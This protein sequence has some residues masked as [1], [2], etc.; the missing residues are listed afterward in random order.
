MR[1]IHVIS[2]PAAGGAENYVRDLAINMATCGHRIHV[3]FLQPASPSESSKKYEEKFLSDLTKNGVSY[4]FIGK[5]A[6]IFPWR[7]AIALFR[8]ARGFRA[9]IVH[10]H[11]YYALIFSMLLPFSTVVYTHHSVRV[12]VPRMA[13]RI[14]DMKVSAYV[15]I[16]GPCFRLLKDC[17][18]KPVFQIDN[19]VDPRRLLSREPSCSEIK[20]LNQ[21][22]R[23]VYVGRLVALKNVS[24]ILRACSR[25]RASNY[26]LTIVGDGPERGSLED[27]AC[28]LGISDKV[29]FFGS[30]PSVA[31]ILRDSEVFLMASQWEGLPISQ[32]EASIVGLP[33]IV[34]DVG[35]CK[36]VVER[37]QSGVSVMAED[38]DEYVAQLERMIVD[39]DYRERLSE[40][41]RTNSAYY[42]IDRSSRDHIFLYKKLVE[43]G[44]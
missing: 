14:F 18:T 31:N 16:C 2:A 6:R 26:F 43:H 4:S 32:I 28:R 44:A 27:L 37:C 42:H 20:Q 21:V 11:L 3:V 17:S 30:V 35:G 38:E 12:K 36:E 15:G 1:I 23:L 7:G 22:V 41:A 8:A 39:K 29:L 34:T 40:M 24:L 19:G 33:M 25:L 9:D 5:S 13:Y 10:C